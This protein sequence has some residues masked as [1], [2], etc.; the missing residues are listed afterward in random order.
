[1]PNTIKYSTTG[2]TFSLKKGNLFIGVGDVGKGPST[3]TQTYNGVSPVASGYTIYIYNPAQ[4]SN[5]SFY[6]ANNDLELITFT[7]NISGQSFTGVTQCLNWYATQ[8]NYVCVNED[9]ESIVTNGLVLNL[10]AGFTP[11]YTSSGTTW[12]DLAYSGNNGTLTNGP[13]FNSTNGGSIVFDGV[14]DFVNIPINSVFNTPSVTFE[15]W[16]NLQTINDRHILYVNWRGNSLEV[17]SNRSVTM[18]NSSSQG[19]QGSGTSGGVF[20]WDNWAH[21][22]GTYDDTAQTLKTYVNG[23]LLSTRTSTPS[24]IYSVGVHKISGTNYGGEVKGKIAIVRH[25][26]KALSDAEVSQNYNA[27]KSRFGL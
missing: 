6:S 13:T 14:D 22:V 24:T 26:N 25:Y 11:S 12:Y 17:N 7:N 16:A 3:A 23:V 10:D 19:Q 4:A 21:F 20:N 15:V 27:Q 18:Y 9:Y 5:V 1:M 2:D 8:T